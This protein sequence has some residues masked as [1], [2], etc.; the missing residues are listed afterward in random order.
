MTVQ[1]KTCFL[2]WATAPGEME[3]FSVFEQLN[4]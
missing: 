2:T 4:Y 1:H 3:T